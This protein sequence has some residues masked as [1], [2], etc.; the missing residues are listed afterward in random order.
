[1]YCFVYDCCLA[2]H[3]IDQ[4]MGQ[5]TT[6]PS[7]GYRP[8]QALSG[9]VFSLICVLLLSF[10]AS[11][12]LTAVAQS[13]TRFSSG[14]FVSPNNWDQN[15]SAVM[16]NSAGGTWRHIT[17][18]N[19]TGFR[20]FRFYSAP[21]GGTIYEP[22]GASDILLNTNTPTNLQTTGSGKA[23]YIDASNTTD[24][25]VFKT[26]GSGSPGS[27]RVLIFRIQGNVV[28]VPNASS[29]T[30]SAAT[31]YPGQNAVITA[32]ASS[33]LPL[34]QALYLRYTN[35]GFATST[36][37]SMSLVS[38]S[39]YSAT[40]PASFNTPGANISYYVFT[41][42]SGLS[43]PTTEADFYTINLQNNGGT[44]YNYTVASAYTSSATGLWSSTSSWQNGQLPIT[45]QPVQLNHIMTLDVTGLSIS[46]LSL[47]SGVS[48]SMGGNNLTLNATGAATVL[49][50]TSASVTTGSGV[51][52]I[53]GT[54]TKS[55]SGTVSLGNTR[56][57]TD[58][59]F[60]TATTMTG[61]LTLAAGGNVVTNA[62][63]YGSS[64]TLEYAAGT[65][66]T[67]G[68]EWSTTSGAGYPNHVLV[69]SGTI[70]ATG[71]IGTLQCAGNLEVTM[72]S[73]LNAA[74]VTTTL[75]SNG[76]LTV[77]GTLIMSATSGA[78]QHVI[79]NV[80]F[81]TGSVL[82]NNNAIFLIGGAGTQTI[83][84]AVPNITRFQ[85]SKSGGSLSV[86][87]PVTITQSFSRLGGSILNANNLNLASGCGIT[88][89]AAGGLDTA[90]TYTGNHLVIYQST[91]SGTTGHDL[92]PDGMWSG[93]IVVVNANVT[94]HRN[95]ATASGNFIDMGGNMTLSTT[96]ITGS[97]SFNLIATG[98]LTVNNAA[99]LSGVLSCNVTSTTG[100]NVTLASSGDLGARAGFN[101][102]I[103]NTAASTAISHT[104]AAF[105]CRRLNL[106]NNSTW[107]ANDQS[108]TISSSTDQTSISLGTGAVFTAGTG[109]IA[110]NGGGNHTLANLI[111][112]YNVSIGGGFLRFASGETIQNGLTILASGSINT[113]APNYGAGSTLFY[114][115]GG[116][117]NRALEWSSTSGPGFP[118]NV[119]VQTGNLNVEG[120]TP[121]IARAAAGTLT[122]DA[123]ATMNMGAMSVRLTAANYQINGNLV[124]STVIGGDLVFTN[125][126]NLNSG[127]TLT[128]NSREIVAATG[129]SKTIGGTASPLPNIELLAIEGGSLAFSS[130]LTLVNRFRMTPGTT[131]NTTNLTMA[132]G[133]TILRTGGTVNAPPALAG[134]VNLLYQHS[135]SLSTDM[136]VPTDQSRINSI[137]MGGSGTL[138][139]D[140]NY[141]IRSGG[142]FVLNSGTLSPG[143]FSIGGAGTYSQTGGQ[144]FV[145]NAGGV[146]GALPIT[147]K[148]WTSG[149]IALAAG[150]PMNFGVLAGLNNMIVSVEAAGTVV[151]QEDNVV[152]RNLSISTGATYNQNGKVLTLVRS[153]GTAISNSGTFIHGNGKVV[154]TS[155]GSNVQTI[156]GT[157]T[158]GDVDITPSGI[159]GVHFSGSITIAGVF[160]INP[161]SFVTVGGPIY[162]TGSTLRYNTGS[163]YNI[164][165]EWAAPHNVEVANNTLLN[166]GG[167]IP[168][169][170]RTLAGNLIVEAGS[171]ASIN[172]PSARMTAP[173]NVGGSI[174]C[175]GGLFLSE[176]FGGDL[177]LGGDLILNTGANFIA[178]RRAI[179][180]N[181]SSDQL[182]G[183]TQTGPLQVQFIT[184]NKPGG[185][186]TCERDLEF[187]N[188]SDLV[189]FWQENGHTNLNDIALSAPGSGTKTFRVDNGTL[190]TGGTSLTGMGWTFQ[191]NVGT[192]RLGGTVV[193][194]K[195]GDEQVLPV[196]YQSLTFEGSGNR[197]LL[198]N[199]DIDKRLTWGGSTTITGAFTI[200][201]GAGA[202]LVYQGTAQQ[203]L[204]V[205]WP[206]TSAPANV[207]IDNQVVLNLT[208][209]RT[210]PD[211]LRLLKGDI[212]TGSNTLSLGTSTASPG[213][214][215]NNSLG[216]IRGAFRRW[217]PATAASYELPVGI[218]QTQRK[219]VV[220]FTSAPS[221][222]GT[223]TASYFEGRP[224][225]TGLPFIEDGILINNLGA[226][227]IWSVV[228]GDGLAGG[229]YS[230][231]LHGRDFLGVNDFT[232][233]RVVKRPSILFP[234][235]LVG[236]GVAPTGDNNS[237]IVGRAGLTS[238][239]E[240]AIA[241]QYTE[242]PLPVDLLSFS[243]SAQDGGQDLL[244]W[245]TA[246]ERNASH[247]ILSSSTDGTTYKP[248]A[249]VKAAGNSAQRRD[250]SQLVHAASLARKGSGTATRYYRLQQYDLDGSLGGTWFAS[251]SGGGNRV[252][253]L[254][255]QPVRSDVTIVL[256]G[257]DG[258]PLQVVVQDALGRVVSQRQFTSVNGDAR[259]NLEQ[260]VLNL[261]PGTYMLRLSTAVETLAPVRVVKQ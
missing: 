58:V 212:F 123:G 46:S 201:Y 91:Y 15:N 134:S 246:T 188:G 146:A 240:F 186:L 253:K 152:I 109:T 94:P 125:S 227:G 206:T 26:M 180:F 230:I 139:L 175:A 128:N 133:A 200:A 72:S 159:A 34:G 105:T 172:E 154:F 69:N 169:V 85:V 205:E 166:L 219:A 9:N 252:I 158:L 247:F 195:T 23:Y 61:F 197:E 121:T 161:G 174:I 29:V 96:A 51:L 204:G 6:Q 20:Y 99:G 27:S 67:R 16:E 181:G 53:S 234:W 41:S 239:S 214:L 1:M 173:L 255:P 108:L 168:S 245:S 140:R 76:N 44:N 103:I 45:G 88:Y 8:W 190:T 254:W 170:P 235:E 49:N 132:D 135:G 202:T 70:L 209:S 120:G 141:T 107:N 179:T 101:N 221:T 199:L 183:G 191:D 54:G 248:V 144:L 73:T 65:S 192:G 256:D 208:A 155:S 176:N 75:R 111:S 153:S 237:P 211:T 232:R 81:G 86:N 136:E 57:L 62:P 21:S 189:R 43:I 145:T 40:I 229:T 162:A 210:V 95:I 102:A 187:N 177:N 226:N 92:P 241:G 228:T 50:A 18:T 33:T 55:I 261:S 223:L 182:F 112:P 59:N 178:N 5:T 115:T 143:A 193:F 24:D 66:V 116:S 71:T 122:I 42:G 250:Y 171:A 138:N 64:S 11:P 194:N 10:I 30:R 244:Q 25:W 225:E 119:R 238:F 198:A 243:A 38:G 215:I 131:T 142:F 36:I 60:G 236:T 118:V 137:T 7:C 164:S 117:Y 217:V 222:G 156:L 260:L 258:E 37:T 184:V 13:P 203:D 213:V 106:G 149:T 124:L 56:L 130:P 165:V 127:C 47:A 19:G 167:S 104:A 220:N 79:G 35:N 97:G 110:F 80:A 78:T 231:E 89:G 31:I 98:Q 14:M 52:T 4:S 84:G 48:L 100:C 163:T 185:T 74:A 233:L 257:F 77:N 151:T 251:V 3:Q 157:M 68:L 249:N 216:A 32:V 83:T 242:N 22:N 87:T 259:K 196:R 2:I 12:N 150:G 148:T 93:L 160:T 39:S 17:K 113:V 218:V 82:T 126:L 207:V 28:T 224:V 147:N 90:P 114:N 63:M 129:S